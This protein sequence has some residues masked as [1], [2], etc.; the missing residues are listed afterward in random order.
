MHG[1]SGSGDT[2][3][4]ALARFRVSLCAQLS[5]LHALRPPHLRNGRWAGLRGADVTLLTARLDQMTVQLHV[6]GVESQVLACQI[7]QHRRCRELYQ[8]GD[9]S[10][11]LPGLE[12]EPRPYHDP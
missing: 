5:A 6:V 7:G 10:Y 3:L 12:P 11:R 1:G 2:E 9:S 8:P 4:R